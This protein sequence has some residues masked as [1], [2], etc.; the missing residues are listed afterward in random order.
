MREK[1]NFDLHFEE[2]M[3]DPEFRAG[4]EAMQPKMKV[5]RAIIEARIETGLTQAEVAERSGL[6]Q[7]NISRIESGRST[8]TVKT[9]MHL[10]K[11]YGKELHIEFR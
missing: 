7:S 3:R 9:L 5:L 11:G 2:Q 8:P 1:S 4:Y 10:A 6:K